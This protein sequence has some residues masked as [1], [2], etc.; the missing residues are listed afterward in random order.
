MYSSVDHDDDKE[1]LA[2]RFSDSDVNSEKAESEGFDMSYTLKPT[3]RS[4][5]PHITANT[6]G[7]V[8]MMLVYGLSIYAAVLGTWIVQSRDD[9]GNLYRK[10]SAYCESCPYLCVIKY[11]C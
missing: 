3:R 2:P 7:I 4:R 9:N 8:T 5:L 6:A 10:T 1:D 11:F